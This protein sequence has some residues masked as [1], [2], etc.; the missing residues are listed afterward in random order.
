MN[1]SYRK[2]KEI[3]FIGSFEWNGQSNHSRLKHC[4]MKMIWQRWSDKLTVE[5]YFLGCLFLCFKNQHNH[6]ILR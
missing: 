5:Y 4:N 6:K 3:K 2:N 1:L